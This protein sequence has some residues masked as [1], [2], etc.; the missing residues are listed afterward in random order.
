[1]WVGEITVDASVKENGNAR[2]TMTVDADPSFA[3]NHV[4]S[5]DLLCSVREADVDVRNSP[6]ITATVKTKR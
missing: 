4:S 2:I 3:R 5:R 6:G 1:M